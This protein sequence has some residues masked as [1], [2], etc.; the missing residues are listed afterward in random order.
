MALVW[1]SWAGPSGERE[2]V[3]IDL[4]ASGTTITEK[5]FIEAESSMND[6]QTMKITGA[7]S[8]TI[9]YTANTPQAGG[10]QLVATRTRTG[11]RGTSYSYSATVS[12]IYTG[13]TASVSG[14]SITV[15]AAPPSAPGQPSV[16]GI[17]SGKA[18]IAWSA[19]TSNNG[20]AVTG[21]QIQ[22]AYDSG[23]TAGVSTGS[24]S[25]ASYTLTTTQANTT[26]WVRVRAQ[27]SAGYGAWSASRSFTT[28]PNTPAA[29]SGVTL[30]RV[31][32]G[33]Q[34][35]TWTNNATSAAPYAQ[36]FV[37]RRDNVNTAWV[38][39]ATLSGAPTSF[40]DTSTVANRRYEYIV[41][42]SNSGGTSGWTVSTAINTTPAAP[43][44]VAA[45]KSG[46]NIAVS[47]V[48]NSAHEG[49]TH[50][51]VQDNPGGAGWTNVATVGAEDSWTHTSVNASVTHQYR[52]VAFTASQNLY[53]EWS[54]ASA[55]VQLLAPPLAPTVSFPQGT[56]ID[57]AQNIRVAWEH[58]PV[59][60]TAQTQYQLQWRLNGGTWTQSPIGDAAGFYF[61]YDLQPFSASGTLDVQVRTRGEHV[62]FGPWSAVKSVQLAS[63]PSVV[64]NSPDSGSTLDQS[65]VTTT[66]GYSSDDASPQA[67]WE[68]T[69]KQGSSTLE[70]RAG[71]GTTSNVAFNRALSDQQTY[72][73][74]VRV[75]SA[76]GLWSDWD[77]SS[78]T[79]DFPMP[80][81]VEVIPEWDV[82]TGAVSL[83]FG[84][85]PVP[86]PNET[87]PETLDVQRQIGDG[88]WVTI[89][90]DLPVDGAVIDPLPSLRYANRYRA[91]SKTT[92]PT[93]ADGTP[94]EV[95][96]D[97]PLGGTHFYLNAGAGFGLVCHAPGH[98]SDD[99]VTIEQST[100]IFAGRPFPVTFYG[101]HEE[102][103]VSFTGPLID[104]A[105]ERN[106]WLALLRARTVVCCRDRLGRRIFGTLALTLT[107]SGGLTTVSGTIRQGDYTE[108][109]L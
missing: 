11:T 19:P 53:S 59:D 43:S 18:N 31:N 66:W 37:N 106:E 63:V 86:G 54:S 50:H 7:R 69:L 6:G 97:A 65:K 83:T 12:G 42:A 105:T 94:I 52:V 44:N 17:T 27:N 98:T 108:G 5:Y 24:T 99:T 67:Q 101:E 14:V 71:T 10:T 95:T 1:G 78:F 92:L 79:T 8:E 73:I 70:T 47:W 21:Y 33:S 64:I 51:V 39:V 30:T 60:T 77:T 9:T 20:A 87:I 48:R 2:R 26:F 13:A 34:T 107:T 76:S 25:T 35:V 72:T 80:V 56:V 45:V 61:G 57:R 91:I 75:R 15:P 89:A 4:T 102:Y 46:S 82:Q 28:L 93:S 62:S 84:D 58:N 81:T 96:W 55:V 22:F 40:T 36:V 109:A 41:A 104:D 29:P 74:Q 88:D 38:R 16:S 85:L 23:F 32:D 49:V 103:Q 3:G 90:V 68:A 100:H